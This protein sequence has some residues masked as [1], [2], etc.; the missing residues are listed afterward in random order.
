MKT[1]VLIFFPA[2]FLAGCA[3]MKAANDLNILPENVARGDPDNPLKVKEY[4]QTVLA[5]PDGREVKAYERKAYSVTTKKN[6]FVSHSFYVFYK[7][8][9]MEHTLVFTATPKGSK[10]NGT[11]MLDAY[12][13]VESY[14][15]FLESSSGNPWEVVE[16]HS[17][18]GGASL[19]LLRTTQ[20]ILDRLNKRYT[21]FGP[22]SVRDLPWYH[23]LWMALV[24]PPILTWLPMLILGIHTDNCTSAVLETMVW[25]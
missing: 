10:L 3:S 22:A 11:W 8:K 4:L 14:N 2:V 21:F 9:K 19:N 23:H 12:S 17:R 20:S 7:D 16:H 1:R 25:E 24:P 15:L 18:K 5:S 6:I 13:D